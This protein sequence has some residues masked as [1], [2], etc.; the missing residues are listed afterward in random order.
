M[1]TYLYKYT[2]ICIDIY[3][4]IYILYTYI[5]VHIYI[6]IYVCVCVIGASSDV[7]QV[8]D[9]D[10]VRSSLCPPLKPLGFLVRYSRFS[11][12]GSGG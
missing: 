1:Y 11:K 8:K 10:P 7:F 5:C 12:I 3:V 6:Y 4:Y 9:K 2:F